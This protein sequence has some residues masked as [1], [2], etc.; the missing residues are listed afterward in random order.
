MYF[1]FQKNKFIDQKSES[2]KLAIA[3]SDREINWLELKNEVEIYKLLFQDLKIPKGHPV[4]IYGDKEA[5][6]L[7]ILIALVSMD[8]PYIP[9]D[10]S[11]PVEWLKKVKSISNSNIIVKSGEYD[12]DLVFPIIVEPDLEVTIHTS[13]K[14]HTCLGDQ[15]N[16]LRYIMF[17]SGST[18]EPKFIQISKS[19]LLSFIRWLKKDHP[20]SP[21]SIF[22]NQASFSFDLSAYNIYAT[23]ALG[24]SIV[25]ID[26]TT[27]SKPEVFYKRLNNYMVN[28]WISTPSFAYLFITDKEF[29][30]DNLQNLQT[31]IFIGEFFDKKLLDKIWRRFNNATLIN[32]Y[33]PTE[34]TVATCF[35]YCTK[36]MLNDSDEIPI[37]MDKINGR[38]Y[39]LNDMKEVS[40]GEIVIVGDQVF[41]GYLKAGIDEKKKYFKWKGKRAYRTG[42]Y[43]Y[44]K[45]GYLYYSGRL[46]NQIKL[47]G[48]RI[49]LD[50][51]NRVIT[52][53]DYID[54]AITLGLKRKN[55]VKKIISI[56]IINPIFSNERIY[57]KKMLLNQISKHIPKYMLPADIK[58]ITAFPLNLN[59]KIDKEKLIQ[60]YIS[61]EL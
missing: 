36:E 10:H 55:I 58:T 37:G 50:F 40:N 29:C 25:L 47:N 14:S 53:I 9:F 15:S 2:L 46:D 11:Y 51:I 19:S 26:E 27:Y 42:D 43:G 59:N 35:A 6:F 60:M 8:I 41:L 44:I 5:A 13:I 33:G 28:T 34:T 32:S 39:L 61:N 4:I 48:Y 20:F 1:D 38:I 16:P 31:F 49:E 23:F 54:S 56:I 12:I 24:G 21:Q 30:H 57:S 22:M 18:G 45:N 17:T 52:K 3:G 7:V